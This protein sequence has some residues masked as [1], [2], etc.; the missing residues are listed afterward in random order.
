MNETTLQPLYPKFPDV[1]N[2]WMHAFSPLVID[3]KRFVQSTEDSSGYFA[4]GLYRVILGCIAAVR[5]SPY[6]TKQG[7]CRTFQVNYV[8]V[9]PPR[10]FSFYMLTA[11]ACIAAF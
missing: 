7:C 3:Y 11:V 8:V 9:V 2:Y 5:D 1:S 4:K 6:V 10:V